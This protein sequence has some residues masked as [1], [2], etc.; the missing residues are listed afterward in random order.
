MDIAELI[1][2]GHNAGEY[3]DQVAVPAGM[4]AAVQD[5]IDRADPLGA[6]VTPEERQAMLERNFP[7]LVKAPEVPAP[8]PVS[9]PAPAPVAVVPVV[10]PLPVAPPAPAV[11]AGP[12]P[13]QIALLELVKSLKE[14]IA[15]AR[16][17]PEKTYEQMDPVERLEYD[18][19]QKVRKEN[20]ATLASVQAEIK[21]LREHNERLARE[22][23][24]SAMAHQFQNQVVQHVSTSALRPELID[25]EFVTPTLRDTLT[26]LG[27]TTA[28]GYRED[29]QKATSR[30]AGFLNEYVT[31]IQKTQAKRVNPQV[32]R[33]AA[34]P[35]PVPTG[36]PAVGLP[37]RVASNADVVKYY[38]GDRFKASMDGYRKVP[39]SAS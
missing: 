18:V 25:P 10:A 1:A 30:L 34:L 11:P 28:A 12:S 31:A 20:E 19:A 9:T 17:P 37:R 27:L 5:Y 38:G 36:Q 32:Q 23:E 35:V 15:A 16:K 22:A 21:A 13:E 39:A 3:A 8:A 2:A 24:E 4:E 29:A 14:D 26:E 7:D 33:T 6:G